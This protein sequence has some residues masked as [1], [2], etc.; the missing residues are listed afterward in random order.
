MART[1]EDPMSATPKQ[2][3]YLVSLL[4]RATGEHCRFVSQHAAEI[5]RRWGLS[6]GQIGRLSKAQASSMI[7][8]LLAETKEA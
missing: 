8:E 6:T 1:K 7:D 3:E 2:L 5:R 4:N